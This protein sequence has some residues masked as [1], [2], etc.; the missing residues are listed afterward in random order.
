MPNRNELWLAG[1]IGHIEMKWTEKGSPF[2]KV[3]LYLSKKNKEGE[4]D[5]SSYYLTIWGTKGE[6][7]FKNVQVKDHMLARCE[8]GT[9]RIY[10]DKAYNEIKVW[11]CWKLPD[12]EGK[13]WHPSVSGFWDALKELE[14]TAQRLFGDTGASGGGSG[15]KEENIDIPF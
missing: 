8:L 6:E 14:A 12:G 5:S 9:P 1:K 10:K 15:A 7:L 13:S 11:D 4:W 2:C 3:T